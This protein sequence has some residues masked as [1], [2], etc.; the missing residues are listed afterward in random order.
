M[1]KVSQCGQVG[2]MSGQQN[3]R[4]SGYAV[5]CYLFLHVILTWLICKDS[6]VE[7]TM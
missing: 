2:R 4:F 6:S 1:T 7:N 3:I 5:S